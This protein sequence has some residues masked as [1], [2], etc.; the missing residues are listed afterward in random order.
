MVK[1]T[2]QKVHCNIPSI[3]PCTCDMER[4][5]GERI[6]VMLIVILGI[7]VLSLVLLLPKIDSRL[8]SGFPAFEMER[9]E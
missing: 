6:M 1:T 4:F 7:L 8:W 3:L 9:E 2:V 5:T